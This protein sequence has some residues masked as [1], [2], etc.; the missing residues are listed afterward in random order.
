MFF[1]FVFRSIIRNVGYAELRLHLGNKNEKMFFHFVF[2][3]ICTNF[4]TE[5]RK[6]S[7]MRIDIITV[8]P[9]LIEPFTQ[10][11]ILG[12]AQKKG[13]AEIQHHRQAS[14]GG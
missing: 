8:L 10:E 11:S 6:R 3:S 1:H 5:N 9:E 7:F 14:A 12:R 13:L 4:A 2:R